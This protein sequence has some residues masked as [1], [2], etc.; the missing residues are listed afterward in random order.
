MSG[1]EFGVNSVSRL[2]TITD[3]QQI[4]EY[5]KNTNISVKFSEQ[6]NNIFVNARPAQ[7][8]NSTTQNLCVTMFN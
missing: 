1:S 6:F 4:W 7:K 8:M 5:Y 3:L 2:Q